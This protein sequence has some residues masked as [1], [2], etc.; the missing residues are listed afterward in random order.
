MLQVGNPSVVN[1]PTVGI[2]TS[3]SEADLAIYV[4]HR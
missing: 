1:I 4:D 3:D 2:L